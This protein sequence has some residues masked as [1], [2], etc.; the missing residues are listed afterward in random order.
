MDK[1]LNWNH[2]V[3]VLKSLHLLSRLVLN[4]M[5]VVILECSNKIWYAW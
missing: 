2:I 3:E 4:V 5:N 1:Y